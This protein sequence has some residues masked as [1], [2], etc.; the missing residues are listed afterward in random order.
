MHTAHFFIT[1]ALRCCLN[2]MCIIADPP[3]FIAIFKSTDLDHAKFAA[4][5][6]WVDKGAGK[7]VMGGAKYKM[8]LL[9]VK[10]VLPLLTELERKGKIIRHDSEKVDA[11]VVVVK[12]I[13][14]TTD[15]DDPHLVAL[16]RLTGCRLICLRD[17]RAHRFL[18]D[19]K[20]YQ[21]SSNRPSLYTQKTHSKLLCAKNL[22]PCCK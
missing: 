20:F 3:T 16:V 1:R 2:Q 22:A 21:S 11:D 4:V 13:E 14:P 9:A 12:T 19:I 10:S 6:D 8:E 18:R 15:F 5:R 17:P 7:F